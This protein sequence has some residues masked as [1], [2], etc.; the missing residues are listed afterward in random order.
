MSVTTFERRL[1]TEIRWLPRRPSARTTPGV[2]AKAQTA[3]EFADAV[4]R[5]LPPGIYAAIIISR[6]AFEAVGAHL[7]EDVA[8]IVREALSNA[9][10]HGA[11]SK[12][13]VDL[14]L[15]NG[16]A[17][18]TVQDN[19]AGFA[20]ETVPAGRGMALMESRAS[21]LR[22]RLLVLGIPGMGTTVQVSFPC[23]EDENELH[24][25]AAENRGRGAGTNHTRNTGWEV[26]RWTR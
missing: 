20:A 18:L 10:R 17:V 21:H 5:T 19:G 26:A 22:G 3:A 12:V 23:C 25:F 2:T 11:P 8:G 4:R 7:L 14:R 6:P 15:S 13:A 24:P 9:F 1:A 16:R